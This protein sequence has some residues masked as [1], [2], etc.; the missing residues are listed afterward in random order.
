VICRVLGFILSQETVL[1][2]VVVVVVLGI[3]EELDYGVCRVL[4]FDSTRQY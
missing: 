4:G 3:R 1:V 2:V